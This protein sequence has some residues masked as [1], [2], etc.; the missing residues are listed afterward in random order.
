MK[1][2]MR[3]RRPEPTNV[4]DLPPAGADRSLYGTVVEMPYLERQARDQAHRVQLR[5]LKKARRR[6]QRRHA[7]QLLRSSLRPGIVL[8]LDGFGIGLLMYGAWLIWHPLAWVLA[9]LVCIA[10]ALILDSS[11]PRGGE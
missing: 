1:I 3:T 10:L 9:G 6:A 7:R 4:S 8:V 11:S 5:S 2:R